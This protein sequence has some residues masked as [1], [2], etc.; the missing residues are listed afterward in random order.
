MNI[1]ATD[2][3]GSYTLELLSSALKRKTAQVAAASA[4]S[5]ASQSGLEGAQ[6]AHVA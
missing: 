1:G 2:Q 6:R 4:A 3:Y 5:T